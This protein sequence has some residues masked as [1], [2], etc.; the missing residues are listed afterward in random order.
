LE[1]LLPPAGTDIRGH[2]VSEAELRSV[3]GYEQ[4]P[5][6]FTALMNCLD[7]ELRLITPSDTELAGAGESG[8]QVPPPPRLYQLT[9]DFLVRA[10][11]GWLNQS[12][13]RTMRG[14]AELRLAEYADAYSARQE[15]R[16]LPSFREWLSLLA[17]TRPRTWQPSARRMMHRASRHHA[18]RYGLALALAITLG[19]L[20][21][22][23]MVTIHAEGLVRALA[24]SDSRDVPRMVDALTS[25]PAAVRPFL[26]RLEAD[27]QDANEH[28]R[29]ELGLV[30]VGE[31]KGEALFEELL[32]AESSLAVAIVEV[33][34]RHGQLKAL[35][36]RL[37]EVASDPEVT[38]PRRLRASAA[39]ARQAPR[40]GS[41]EQFRA[42]APDVAA[43]LISDTDKNP[44]HFGTWVDAFLPML[45]WLD[46]PLRRSFGNP[47]AA[48]NERL[49][50][51]KILAR[52]AGARVDQLLE[53]ALQSTPK[54][55][56]VFAEL[57]TTRA[58]ALRSKLVGEA[59]V[60]IPPDATEEEKD[61]MAR[62]Q[63]NAIL[64]LHRSDQND[65]LWSSL[66][67]R[68]D[69]RLRSF[70]L[71]NMRQSSDAPAAWINRLTSEDDPGVQQALILVLGSNVAVPLLE[72]QRA[73]LVD[74]LMGI[75]RN[76]VDSGVHSAAEWT[77]GRLG[78]EAESALAAARGELSTRGIQPGFHWYVTKSGLT[79]AI[80]EP[81]TGPVTLGS[82]ETEPGRDAKD[83]HTWDFT[84]NWTFA[85]STMEIT[86]EQ[87]HD[88][89]PNYK[90]YLNEFAE[91]PECPANAITWLEA[92]QFCRLLCERENL[93]DSEMA[94]PPANKQRT[95]PYP[96]FRERIGYRLPLEC[97][98]E[99]A[100]RAGT[101]TPRFF[102]Y[103]PDLLRSY[104]CY[105]ANSG[106]KSRSVG[107]V[108]P[109]AAGMFDALGNVAEWCFDEFFNDRR[110]HPEPSVRLPGFST[111][112]AVRGNGYSSSSRMMRSA[113]RRDASHTAG[114]YADGFRIAHTVRVQAAEE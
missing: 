111:R 62:R 28:V 34:M 67:H 9:H 8:Q 24:A 106:G 86:Q 95:G 98:W 108:W 107:G 2:L 29:A 109:N 41:E 99:I 7:H 45:T 10:I 50:A 6:E 94:V 75:Y 20:V 102:G 5:L 1:R 96:D 66:V 17:L 76:D 77:L 89:F 56:E 69:P 14:R 92:I 60:S 42:I 81:P 105:I 88:L 21:Y 100:C 65:Y 44:D 54:Q 30:A 26:E 110:E 83:E 33:L 37:W 90:E 64:L 43:L 103:A 114:S 36:E 52:F 104:C 84:L 79:M 70:L 51:A 13:R 112:Y 23:R 72:S 93:N 11:R 63:A 15:T 38:G 58:S 73:A 59:Q 3:S 25:Y 80:F 4:Q 22:N 87:Y 48:E 32:K 68:P 18:W 91:T 57:L 40:S 27:P 101:T 12:R 53:L 31:T 47:D 78:P 49:L 35:N 16:Q 85:I 46:A 113:N 61:R 74:T 19:L 71:D 97:E 39:L 55:F 82:P